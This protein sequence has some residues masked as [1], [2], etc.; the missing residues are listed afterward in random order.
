MEGTSDVRQTPLVQSENGPQ[1]RHRA[2]GH[3]YSVSSVWAP[4]LAKSET[5]LVPAAGGSRRAPLGSRG[6]L[7][8]ARVG[9]SVPGSV[10]RPPVAIV[11]PI[12]V[13]DPGPPRVDGRAIS[14][15]PA[16]D[17]EPGGSRTSVPA[18]RIP[19]PSRGRDDSHTTPHTPRPECNGS[20]VSPGGGRHWSLGAGRKRRTTQRERDGPQ[21]TRSPPT[22][23]VT[24]HFSNNNLEVL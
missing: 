10:T 22:R 8:S 6:R 24:N 14:R 3:R 5:R 19:D 15:G 20:A 16:D 4:P 9:P 17:R 2:A 11:D 1:F 21:R 23:G 7:R 18:E 12:A 13:V